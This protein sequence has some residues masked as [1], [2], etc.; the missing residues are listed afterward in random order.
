MAIR[1]ILEMKI[2]LVK[3][4][5]QKIKKTAKKNKLWI[6]YQCYK[7]IIKY[8][9][10]ICQL[11]LSFKC[12]KKILRITEN[13]QIVCLKMVRTTYKPKAERQPWKTNWNTRFYLKSILPEGKSK[14]AFCRYF[15]IRLKFLAPKLIH[16]N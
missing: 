14:M 4:N 5:K 11:I 8:T 1:T 2:K 6:A 12:Q 16:C 10:T 15:E 3:Y 9:Y 7:V 13:L